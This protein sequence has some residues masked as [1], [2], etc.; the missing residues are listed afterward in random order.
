MGMFDYT[1]TR[2]NFTVLEKVETQKRFAFYDRRGEG[3]DVS[4]VTWEV[5]LVGSEGE[6]E[7]GATAMHAEGAV[8][9]LMVSLPSMG[10]GTYDY[11]VVAK[12][13]SGEVDVVVAGLVTVKSRAAADKIVEEAASAEE[14]EMRVVVPDEVGKVLLLK[15]Q[16]S[17]FVQG[18]AEAAKDAADRAENAEQEAE[19][20]IEEAV[21]EATEKAENA[22]DR[23]EAA[24][25]RAEEKIEEAVGGATERAEA[26]ADRAEAAADN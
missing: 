23:A 1:G 9:K 21:K 20:K 6:E 5:R 3:F 24:A 12:T 8:N 13:E 4:D 2:Y 15:W 25:D 7:G 22:A 19:K 16:G 17:S 10:A 18:Y 14:S 26:A 11:E